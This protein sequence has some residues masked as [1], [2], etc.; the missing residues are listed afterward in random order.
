MYIDIDID[1]DIDDIHRVFI[2]LTRIILI[3]IGIDDS[4]IICKKSL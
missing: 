4:I 1:G 3:G 2:L